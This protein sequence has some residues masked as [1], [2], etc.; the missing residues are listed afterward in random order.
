MPI[1][2][3]TTTPAPVFRSIDI[4]KVL[5]WLSEFVAP[6]TAETFAWLA[7]IFLHASTVPSLLGLLTGIGDR[8]PTVDMVLLVWLALL[9]LFG[10]AAVQKNLLQI[11]TITLGFCVQATLMAL[12]FFR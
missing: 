1:E 9:C 4:R 12:V 11:I 8:L 5:N 3:I 6:A 10:Q 7:I 2:R